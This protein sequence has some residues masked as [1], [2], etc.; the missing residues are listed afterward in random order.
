MQQAF[1]ES[2]RAFKLCEPVGELVY[3]SA[4]IVDFDFKRAHD[5]PRVFLFDVFDS[6]NLD[7]LI[8]PQCVALHC[9]S[10]CTRLN[11]SRRVPCVVR[12]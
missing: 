10:W 12:D 2:V 5:A 11:D 3:C 1:M 7:N 8:S 9:H 6:I 4:L